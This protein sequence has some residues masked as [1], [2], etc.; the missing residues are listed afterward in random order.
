MAKKS[1]ETIQAQTSAF[2]AE[3]DI[4]PGLGEEIIDSFREQSVDSLEGVSSRSFDMAAAAK[5]YKTYLKRVGGNRHETIA[6]IG[7]LLENFK[8]FQ[9]RVD[10]LRSEG[11]Q[12][13]KYSRPDYLGS[14]LHSDVFVV[15]VD[16]KEYAIR[17]PKDEIRPTAINW[18]IKGSIAA[19]NVPHMEKVVAASYKDGIV[20]SERMPG[21]ELFRASAENL[22][23]VTQEQVEDL[24]DT[25]SE[26]ARLD[27]VL[28]P[29]PHNYFYDTAHGF[30]I[31]DYHGR[32]R[33][34]T[35]SGNSAQ[36]TAIK[37]RLLS[38]ALTH[39]AL[40]I[41]EAGFYHQRP[42]KT[43]GYIQSIMDNLFA[44]AEILD[45]L[46]SV[47]ANRLNGET[48]EGVDK[49]IS[50]YIRGVKAV[51]RNYES[52]IELNGSS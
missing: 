11:A 18:R 29:S 23:Q 26:S 28:D 49:S 12:Y 19:Q 22:R 33:P 9:P 1:L 37:N 34:S 48:K 42:N 52:Q 43:S 20:V 36:D 45:K 5:A 8:T 31:I 16:N 3:G 30:G 47:C 13:C 27:L 35:H 4:R 7:A 6:Q 39:F 15:D 40:V 32:T 2:I 51:I 41:S 46:K 50:Q 38:E 17:L 25:F 10:Q 21:V 24:F 14:G 44:R